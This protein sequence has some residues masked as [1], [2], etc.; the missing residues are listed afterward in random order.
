MVEVKY[1]K[2]SFVRNEEAEVTECEKCG[3]I[4]GEV[5]K[6]ECVEKKENKIKQ[7]FRGV[8][9]EFKGYLPMEITNNDE[10]HI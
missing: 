8:T 5:E 7:N 2:H 1:K 9:K 3:Y 4:W 10:N 6:R